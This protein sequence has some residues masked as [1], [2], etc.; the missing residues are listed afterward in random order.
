M[1]AALSIAMRNTDLISEIE[2]DA[3]DAVLGGCKRGCK[4]AQP[5]PPPQQPPP[6]AMAPPQDRGGVEIVVATGAQAAQ[7]IGGQLG[8]ARPGGATIQRA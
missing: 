7:L 3:L 4:K 6:Q 1:F 5:P 2:R 8:A